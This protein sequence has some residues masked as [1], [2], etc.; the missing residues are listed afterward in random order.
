VKSNSLKTGAGVVEK[1]VEKVVEEGGVLSKTQRHILKAIAAK[2]PISA[3]ELS[4]KIG[5]SPRKIQ[6]H[7]RQL[8]ER[9]ILLREGPD[10]GGS[11]RIVSS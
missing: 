6:D 3:K 4:V 11:W 1:V 2:P 8:R 10:R 7:L 9:G 5:I